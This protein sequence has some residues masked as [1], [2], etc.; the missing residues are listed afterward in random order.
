MIFY[1]KIYEA[2]P[3]K[4]RFFYGFFSLFG[5]APVCGTGEQGSIPGDTQQYKIPWLNWLEHRPDTSKVEGSSPSGITD[6]IS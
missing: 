4:R 2:P 3:K 5:K 6:K 1:V